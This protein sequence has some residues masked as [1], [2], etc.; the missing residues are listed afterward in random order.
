MGDLTAPARCVLPHQQRL[1]C[2]NVG[3]CLHATSTIPTREDILHSSQVHRYRALHL[4]FIGCPILHVIGICLKT[5]FW[6]LHS[7]RNSFH[8]T[9]TSIRN[10]VHK[11]KCRQTHKTHNAGDIAIQEGVDAGR[12]RCLLTL[13][14]IR[15]NCKWI[16]IWWISVTSAVPAKGA[17]TKTFG[18]HRLQH[19]LDCGDVVG[20]GLGYIAIGSEI[21]N[22]SVEG[23]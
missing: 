11:K 4:S 20:I 15:H 12:L 2:L 8:K 10:S 7:I 1:R 3:G 14:D 23:S 9:F 5:T 16:A 21:H 13:L 19:L 18:D 22:L 6:R 17:I